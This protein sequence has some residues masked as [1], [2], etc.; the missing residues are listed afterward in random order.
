MA[1]KKWRKRGPGKV[2]NKH[3][4]EER[5]KRKVVDGHRREFVHNIDS[6]SQGYDDRTKT[7]ADKAAR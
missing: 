5:K 1:D 6:S 3:K 7:D 4:M 2:R